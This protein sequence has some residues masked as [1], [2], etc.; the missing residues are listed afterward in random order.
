M[1]NFMKFAGRS[2]LLFAAVVLVGISSCKKDDDE[3]NSDTINRIESIQYLTENFPP[4]NYEQDGQLYGASVDILEAL[5]EKLNVDLSRKDV[6][7]KNWPEAYQQTLEQEYTMLFSM[8]R[9][10]GR[11]SLFRWVG[12]IAPIR[13]IVVAPVVSFMEI[14]NPVDLNNYTVGIIEDF[15][16]VEILQQEGLLEENMHFY[17]DVEQMY[18]GLIID[19]V[20]C[21]VF[22]EYGNKLIIESLGMDPEDYEEVYQVAVTEDYY[23]FHINTPEDVISIF[24]EKLEELKND[25]TGDGSS[26]YE[27]ILNNYQVIQHI[28]DNITEEMVITLVEETMAD[29]EADAPGTFDLINQQI[30]PYKDPDIPALYVFVYDTAINMM[31]HADNALLVGK[32]FKGKTDAAGR[33]FRDEIVAGALKHGTGWVDYIY[34]KPDQSGLYYKTTYYRLVTG[35]DGEFYVVCAGRFK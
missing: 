5:F 9:L 15:A 16:E 33:K 4:F 13:N 14:D 1:K 25:K 10:P 24:R 26:V 3:V 2:G 29:I 34:T 7:L 11:E 35:S 32:N 31:A 22:S 23:A 12:P 27:K 28:E 17:E 6:Q 19:E 20:D 18:E 8:A 21:V 30:A